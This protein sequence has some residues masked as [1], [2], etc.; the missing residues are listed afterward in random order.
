ME[1]D[2]CGR[3]RTGRQ[4]QHGLSVRRDHVHLQRPALS[5]FIVVCMQDDATCQM[6]MWLRL[7]VPSIRPEISPRD[8][9]TRCSQTK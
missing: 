1:R 9:S 3:A 8:I 5:V 6:M 2:R 7:V 4:R